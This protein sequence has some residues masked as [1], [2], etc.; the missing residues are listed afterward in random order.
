[1]DC[2]N[3]YPPWVMQFD[4]LPGVKKEAN[5]GQMIRCSR[6][7]I[8]LEALKCDVVCANC[9]AIRTHARRHKM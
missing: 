1:M 3:R 5:V 9:H 4:H 2:G 6:E 7:S 8:L